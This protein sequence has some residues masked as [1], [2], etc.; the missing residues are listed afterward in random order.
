MD[1]PE[2]LMA[3]QTGYPSYNQPE[4]PIGEDSLGNAIYSG[5]ELFVVNDEWFVIEELTYNAI[6]VLEAIGADRVLAK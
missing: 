5:D 3:M 6:E 1:H 4:N 2:V